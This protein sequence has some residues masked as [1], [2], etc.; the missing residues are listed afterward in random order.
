MALMH[1]AVFLLA[2]ALHRSYF[3]VKQNFSVESLEC[4]GRRKWIYGLPLANYMN[5]VSNDAHASA[6]GFYCLLTLLFPA[7]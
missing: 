7:E 2:R 3:D 6:P 5:I 1:D 4:G